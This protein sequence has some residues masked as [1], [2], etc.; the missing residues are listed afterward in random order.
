MVVYP[1]TSNWDLI[2]GLL[3]K[4]G[5]GF[6]AKFWIKDS[7]LR[8]P[9]L[10]PLLRALGGIAVVRS[11]T[12]GVVNDMAAQFER[13]READQYFWLVLAPE[14]TRSLKSAWKSG[15]YHVALKANVPVGLAFIDYATRTAG[16]QSVMALSGNVE[17]DMAHIAAELGARKGYHRDQASP[18]CLDKQFEA[19]SGTAKTGASSS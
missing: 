19:G 12:T 5:M 9:V 18:I 2:F 1:H 7:S 15:F 8:V 17:D 16:V 10:G 4:W 14:G 13:A 3:A 11:Q 6:P